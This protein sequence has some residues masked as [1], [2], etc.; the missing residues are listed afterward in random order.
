MPRKFIILILALGLV[1]LAA[2]AQQ[3]IRFYEVDLSRAL[4]LAQLQNKPIFVDTY[5]HWCIPCKKMDIEFRD[6]SLAAFFNEHF[7]N[8]KVNME[9]PKGKSFYNRYPIVFLPTLLFLDSQGQSKG[10]VE[11]LISAEDLLSMGKAMQMNR[12]IPQVEIPAT[13][14]KPVNAKPSKDVPS[15][16]KEKQ[17]VTAPEIQTDI[18]DIPVSES[19]TKAITKKATESKDEEKILYV[20]GDDSMEVPPEILREEAY[21]RMRLMDGSHRKAARKYLETQP[22]WLTEDNIRFIY[23]FLYDT[24]TPEFEF[25]IKNVAEFEKIIGS[26]KTDK[27]RNIIIYNRLESGYPKPD[28]QEAEYLYSLVDPENYKALAASYLKNRKKN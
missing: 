12:P 26:E 25:F 19:G 3:S 20:L 22:D 1:S 9:T 2:T 18:E 4:E 23:D 16:E 24:R 13:A 11:Q 6:K 21:F 15:T 10:I 28:R 27:T 5:T 8:V 7:I 14:S 17:L